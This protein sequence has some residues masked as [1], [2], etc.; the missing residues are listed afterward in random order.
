[1]MGSLVI[2]RRSSYSICECALLLHTGV[3]PDC[4]QV[5]LSAV[6]MITVTTDV[7][8]SG[9]KKGERIK[10]GEGKREEER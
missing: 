4:K 10:R 2:L 7:S 9:R 5:E 1:M 3:V 6:G 8:H